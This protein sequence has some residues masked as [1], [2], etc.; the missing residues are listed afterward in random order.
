MRSKSSP[1]S[2][3]VILCKLLSKVQVCKHVQ[4]YW[5]DLEYNSLLL[6]VGELFWVSDIDTVVQF[7]P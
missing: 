3:L 5:N 1:G 7:H 2:R 4:V 6:S